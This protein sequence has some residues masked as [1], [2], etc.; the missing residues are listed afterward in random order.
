MKFGQGVLPRSA[1]EKPLNFAL[2]RLGCR[3]KIRWTPVDWAR[4]A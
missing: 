1:P 3:A 2:C 4:A